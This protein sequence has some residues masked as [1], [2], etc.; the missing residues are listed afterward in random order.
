MTC[1]EYQFEI[2]TQRATELADN[3]ALKAHVDVCADCAQ[4]YAETLQ[5]SAATGLLQ[6]L[7]PPAG[8]A[9][10]IQRQVRASAPARAPGLLEKLLGPLRAP[11]PALQTRHVF[12]GVAVILVALVLLTLLIHPMG[13]PNAA[14]TIN[15]PSLVQPGGG[16]PVDFPST[17]PS[18]SSGPVSPANAP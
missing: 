10:R 9:Q 3:T 4:A 2:G 13:L 18:H 11:A 17:Q 15:V 16:Q 8:L 6:P 7:T 14:P 1:R 12:A 5:L